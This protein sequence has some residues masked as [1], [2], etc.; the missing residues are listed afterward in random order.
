[1]QL[2]HR[3]CCVMTSHN[4]Q[5]F[6]RTQGTP[7]HTGKTPPM[8]HSD[9]SVLYLPPSPD[10]P[11]QSLID[12]KLI[13]EYRRTWF[14]VFTAPPFVLH[15]GQRSPE[16]AALYAHYGV[17]AALYIT[18][19]SPYSTVVSDADNQ[20][21]QALLETD[22]SHSG[23]AVIAGDGQDPEAQWPPE[24]SLLSLG[25]S[26]ADSAELGRRYRQNAVV[27]AGEDAVPVLLLLR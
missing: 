13:A 22:L 18:A 19:Y 1:M 23:R 8:P 4:P 16:L 6:T 11:V 26:Q 14:H 25:V 2:I 21:A 20:A 17:S 24:H 10:A 12:P 3:D 5:P 27:W 15:I 9:P 7:L